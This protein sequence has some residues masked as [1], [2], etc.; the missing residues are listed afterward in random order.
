M[1]KGWTVD[2]HAQ[3]N[4]NFVC[5]NLNLG[6]WKF[7]RRSIFWSKNWPCLGMG[8]L[9]LPSD[10]NIE[11][12]LQN[13][14][15]LA[16]QC[17]HWDRAQSDFGKHREDSRR[18]RWCKVA[19]QDARCHFPPRAKASPRLQLKI[20][21][22]IWCFKNQDHQIIWRWKKSTNI[23]SFIGTS[24]FWKHRSSSTTRLPRRSNKILSIH[25]IQLYVIIFL[26]AFYIAGCCSVVS[27]LRCTNLKKWQ[28]F[29]H[30][31]CFK[32]NFFENGFKWLDCFR[33]TCVSKAFNIWWNHGKIPIL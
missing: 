4:L 25:V 22:W 13:V 29:S 24:E 23:D 16:G 6:I 27:A 2:V 33:R 5:S 17:P 8:K 11:L 3:N 26:L 21:D 9:Q 18:A 30:L 15:F 20:A 1:L 14:V 7:Q 10:E 32:A 19:T 28:Y 12:Y 31:L